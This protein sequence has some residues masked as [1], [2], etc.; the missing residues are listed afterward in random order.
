[1]GKR[2]FVFGPNGYGDFANAPVV[3]QLRSGTVERIASHNRFSHSF[4]K[5]EGGLYLDAFIINLPDGSSKASLPSLERVER[6]R[7]KM[8]RER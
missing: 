1:M 7:E 4:R 8:L 2:S 3:V 6:E 5:V